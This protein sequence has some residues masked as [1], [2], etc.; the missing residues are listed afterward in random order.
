MG[1]KVQIV[2]D[3]FIKGD[4]ILKES[5]LSLFKGINCK[6]ILSTNEPEI[7]IKF[8]SKEDT[9]EIA[10]QSVISSLENQKDQLLEL[11]DKCDL[12]RFDIVLYSNDGRPEVYLNRDSILWIANLHAD[13]SIDLYRL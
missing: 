11:S 2:M 3:F 8:E 9:L 12:V 5:V 1:N 4:K 10:F 6:T 13:I 7:S